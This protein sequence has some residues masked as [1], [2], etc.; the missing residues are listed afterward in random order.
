M[1]K[2]AINGRELV[3]DCGSLAAREWNSNKL[4]SKRVLLLHDLHDNSSVFDLLVP[5]LQHQNGLHIVALDLPGHG[6]SHSLPVGS[7]YLDTTMMYEIRKFIK[8]IGWHQGD[9]QQKV[10]L[11]ND[12]A[13]ITII[14]HGEGA[15]LALFYAR[16]FPQDVYRIISL[17]FVRLNKTGCSDLMRDTATKLEQIVDIKMALTL[18]KKVKPDLNELSSRPDSNCTYKSVSYKDAVRMIIENCSAPGELNDDEA[19][20]LVDRANQGPLMASN[21]D[22]ITIKK[23]DRLASYMNL[24]T[25]IELTTSNAAYGLQCHLLVVLA[26]NG[27][28]KDGKDLEDLEDFVEYYKKHCASFELAWIEDSDHFFLL[29]KVKETANIINQATR[30][31]C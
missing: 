6:R 5:E 24:R 26:R 14:G 1:D 2:S 21:N 12:T 17:D 4:G 7:M 16:L 8:F 25:F 13:K 3:S 9:D 10:L 28:H 18:K 11:G 29:K 27:R 22:C 20:P 19:V 30:V 23:D 15:S 31:E